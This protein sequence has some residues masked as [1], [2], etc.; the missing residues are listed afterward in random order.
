MIPTRE[1]AW[2]LLRE[3]NDEEHLL[4]HA[5]TVEG[6]MRHF[7]NVYAEDPEL[8]GVVGLLHD[9]DYQKFPDA[10]CK[11]T[12]EILRQ[13]GVDEVV[14]RG[15]ASHGDG[16]CIDLPPE[17]QMEK[18]LYTIDELTGIIA[19][20]AIMRPSRSVMDLEL[21]SGKKKYK[22]KGFAAGCDRELIARGAEKMGM[23]LD[24]VIAHTIQG[25]REVAGEIGLK[26]EL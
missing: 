7:A 11:K 18:T 16:I 1:Q 21:K 10:H 9:L 5:K 20:A 2:E 3:F 13:R 14:A 25:M 22:S 8:W 12:L 24:S 6:V 26:G 23:E 15:C 4:I 17:S 19:A